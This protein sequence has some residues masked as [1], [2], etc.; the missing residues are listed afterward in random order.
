VIS[1]SRH[2]FYPFAHPRRFSSMVFKMQFFVVMK[3]FL[4]LAHTFFLINQN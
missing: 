4:S 3:Y 2:I 1:P